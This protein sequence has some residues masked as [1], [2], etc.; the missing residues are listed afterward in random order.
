MLRR[1]ALAALLALAPS[2]ASAQVN[3]PDFSVAAYVRYVLNGNIT[4]TGNLTVGGSIIDGN[5]ILATNIVAPATPAAGTT[6]IYVDSTSKTPTGKNDAGTL[7]N[8]VTP[9][10][11]S[12]NQWVSAIA[13]NAAV[14]CSAGSAPA[15]TSITNA[16]G[17]DVLLNN[18]ANYFDGPSVAQGVTGTWLATGT[19]TATDTA[20]AA[21]VDC[22]L[23]DGTTV[24]NSSRASVSATTLVVSISLSGVLASPAGNIRISCKDI[25]STS[26][27]ILFNVTGSSKDSTVTAVRIQ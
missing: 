13:A 12:A 2:L 16:I 15:L 10:T 20:G 27:K 5:G 26:G 6:R 25:A 18:T 14:T 9:I 19:A 23:W 24:I 4:I 22:K 7:S 1:L 11:C 8:M 21:N 17:A 3:S